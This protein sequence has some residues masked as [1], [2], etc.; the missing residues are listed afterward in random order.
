MPRRERPIVL[1]PASVSITGDSNAPVT[2]TY[3]GT[4]VVDGSLVPL[5]TAAKD[6]GTIFTAVGLEEFTGRKWLASK[7]DRFIGENPC[8]YVFIEAE[9]GLG[10]TAFAAWLVKTRGYLSHFARYSEGTSVPVALGNLSAQLIMRLGLDDLAPGGMLPEWARTP[11]GFES[12]LAAA[13]RAPGRQ[14]PIVLVT[15]GLDEA[16]SLAGGLPFG[17]PLLLP[18]GVFVIGTYRTG[19]SPRRPDTPATVVP[20][21]KQDP[22]NLRDID[23]YLANE[24][25]EEVLAARLAQAGTDPATFASLLAERCGGVWVYLRYVLHELRIGLRGPDEISDLPAGLHSYYADQVRHWQ[26]DPAWH[27]GLLSL[28]ATLAVA[29]E[30]LS[31]ASLARLAGGLDPAA[32]QRWCDLTIRPLLSAAEAPSADGILQ[33]EIYH[34][35]FRE[36]LN[37]SAGD[38][39]GELDDQPYELLALAGELGQAAAEA[40]SHIC[41]SYLGHFGGLDAGLPALA[42]DLE[43]ASIDSG[44]PLRHLSH[45]LCHIGRVGDLHT[46]LAIAHADSGDREVSTWFAAHDHADSGISYLADVARARS[47]SAVATDH[48][49]NGSRLAPTLGMEIRYALMAASITSITSKIPLDLLP[50]LISTGVW[51]PRHSLD[52]ARRIA[53]PISRLDALLVACGQLDAEERPAALVYALA[54]AAAITDA[55]D[56]A[57][58]L[59]GL[60]PHL[61]EAKQPAILGQ[62]LAA[63]TAIT[64]SNSR[65]KA[66]DRLAPHLPTDLLPQALAAATTITNDLDRAWA[67]TDL[68]P[69]LPTDLLTQALAA[70][71]TI[72]NDDARARALTGLAPY[73]P[74]AK[75][76]AVLARVSGDHGFLG[77]AL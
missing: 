49:L 40:H 6:P 76:P 74:E 2:T 47:A 9:A 27:A 22:L 26:R 55:T 45:H 63:A 67:L 15:D 17:L 53:D 14:G 66:L 38:R 60:A 65:T 33:Y 58:A 10:K 37:G 24:S 51:S 71:T 64:D 46:L 30:P 23:D 1:G 48:D 32:V 5:G 43:T 68:A 36:L 62:A 69:H 50:Q 35:S 19:R 12:L 18:Y 41:D 31:A 34:A 75:Q 59:A 56:R 28:L 61:P 72:T 7:V 42:A 29:R 3:I 73:L 4:L 52:R 8:G 39:P 54:A 44:Y 25:R 11:N 77:P 57:Q 70:A 21:R 13:V 16:D 20:I